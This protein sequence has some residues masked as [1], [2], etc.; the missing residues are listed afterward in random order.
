MATNDNAATFIELYNRLERL[1]RREYPDIPADKGA[2]AVAARQKPSFA[3]MREELDYCREVRN[4]LQHSSRVG[5]ETLVSPSNALIEVLKRAINTIEKPKVARGICTRKADI[6]YA[7]P[8][9]SVRAVL[10]EMSRHSYTHVPVLDDGRVVG[11]FSANTLLAYIFGEGA[12]DV[13]LATALDGATFAQFGDLLA[14]NSGVAGAFAFV[15]E[16]ANAYEVAELFQ[17]ALRGQ[18]RLMMLFVTAHGKQTERL[19]GII[20]AW[21]MAG[22]F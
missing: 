4:L 1:I 3:R 9:G 20:T 2:I 6:L 14:L 7:E 15:A 13:D 8:Q 11:V 10:E 12:Q 22:F 21:D 5:G 17:Q 16:D 19:L 18:Q